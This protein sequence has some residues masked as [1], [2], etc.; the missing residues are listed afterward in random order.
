M[1]A[2][3]FFVA[4]GV[5]EATP[6]PPE[7]WQEDEYHVRTWI[8]DDGLP[9]N[10]LNQILQDERGFI[11]LATLAGLARYDGH[12]FKTF[13]L[14]PEFTPNGYN[15]RS[16][17]E[18]GPDSLILL[19]TN[20]DVVRLQGGK[21]S[22]HPA[23]EFF[24]GL[25]PSEV[26]VAGDGALW[27]GEAGGKVLRWHEGQGRW[28]TP[29]ENPRLLARFSF[30]S[31]S[32]GETWIA[33]GS[34]LGRYHD[35]ELTRVDLGLEEDV[36]IAPSSSGDFF[37]VGT[38]NGLH[39]YAN[40]RL[41][42]VAREVPWQGRLT[43]LQHMFQDR[44]GVLWLATWRTGLHRWTGE[45][46][47][48]I[49][50]DLTVMYVTEDRD[51][52]LWL[53]TIGNGVAQVRLK[54]HRLLDTRY[55]VLEPAS[56]GV[57]VAADDT[58][59]IANGNGGIA[60]FQD[61]RAEPLQ[62]TI[63]GAP[64]A[65]ATVIS[66]PS[67]NL[68][69]GG[70]DGLFHL[71]RGSSAE[72]RQLPQSGRGVNLLFASRSGDVWY[73]ALS[74]QLG[75]YRNGE[76]HGL[77]AADGYDGQV[78]RA[79]AEDPSGRIWLGAATGDLLYMSGGRM[80]RFND[81]RSRR[82]PIHD[83]YV[84]RDGDLWIATA[85]GL[86]YK[87]RE[88]NLLAFTTAHGLAD[89]LLVRMLDDDRGLL[90]FAARSGIFFVDKAGLLSVARGKAER[91]VSHRFGR[92][93]GLS[94]ATPQLNSQPSAGKTADGRLWFATAKGIV[95]IDPASL[96]RHKPAPPVFIDEM[97]I[98][99]V[100]VPIQSGTT[101]PAGRNR[102]ELRFTAPS[103]GPE[104]VQMQHRLEGADPDWVETSDAHAASYSGLAPGKYRL[105]VRVRNG[106][107]EW[108]SVPASLGFTILPAWWQTIWMQLGV[109]A[110]ASALAAWV[111]RHWSQRKL[112][113]RLRRLEQ[114]H[115]LELERARIARN[116]HD[117]LGGS[118]TQIG[119]MAD[120]LR[121]APGTELPP[122]LG[123]LAAQTRRLHVE[124][125]SIIWS[126]SPKNNSLNQLAA[127]MSRYARRLFRYS[128][129]HC[130]VEE[131]GNIPAH[132]LSPDVQH[133]LLAIVKEALNNVLTHA[134]AGQ[135]VLR[136]SYARGIFR[137]VV[138]DNGIGFRP[139]DLNEDEGNGLVNIRTRIA[140]IGGTL[141]LTSSPG[142]GTR[143]AI[144]YPC[145]AAGRQRSRQARRQNETIACP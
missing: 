24:Q 101:V 8:T 62:W 20:G 18:E 1:R 126:V 46:F 134:Q 40:G 116:L 31:G 2:L 104:R 44:A 60:R 70:R 128:T 5:L 103:F 4:W 73:Y 139:D 27:I 36:I 14:P 80:H 127:F 50:V 98:N 85:G 48:R 130:Q 83:L 52:N 94:G 122:A 74:G 132:I 51:Q 115:A 84:D 92:D 72:P 124:L 43:A 57:H 61:G 133:H 16:I 37:W 87:D 58:L 138:E 89:D 39:R 47:T 81:G 11:W 30:V 107:G 135:V 96:Q 56:T 114:E 111:A 140:E 19:P 144:A 26:F 78:I 29:E 143:L 136:T 13:E 49:D 108:S 75:Y 45:A 34:F 3:L 55:G 123:R 65:F 25:R 121:E 95:S 105:Q 110:A 7:L 145:T 112:K 141:T 117:D 59:W 54:N 109:L 131:A 23:S 91:F 66:D 118:L 76:L 33:S 64:G 90:W 119:L 137:L 38:P 88:D 22:R 9:Y 77:T 15:V 28:F 12:Q 63:D 129:T 67:G 69:A 99:D 86:L 100:L 79:M 35:G 97:L 113:S 6:L 120:R 32:A 106:M 142:Q 53:A 42:T 82:Q 102:I 71:P 125:A 68:W 93:Q 10:S 21:Y 41:D 17:A